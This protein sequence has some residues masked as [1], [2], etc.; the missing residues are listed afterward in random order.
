MILGGVPRR[1]RMHNAF[2]NQ[3]SLRR[4][5]KM[6]EEGKMKVLTD[7]VWAMEEAIK[8]RHEW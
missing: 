1:H 8:V 2:I 3:A 6:A 4:V 7:S 5:A